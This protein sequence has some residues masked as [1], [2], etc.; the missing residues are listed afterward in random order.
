MQPLSYLINGQ[1]TNKGA[2]TILTECSLWR[3]D[4]RV[5]DGCCAKSVL[6]TATRFLGAKRVGY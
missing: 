4:S 5:I 3:C 1:R 2:R 6:K